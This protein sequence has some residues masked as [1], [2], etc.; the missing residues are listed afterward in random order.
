MIRKTPPIASADRVFQTIPAQAL[1][2]VLPVPVYVT[3]A[4]GRIIFFNPSAQAFAGREPA[5]GELWCV[6]W[7]MLSPDGTPLP[8]D[9]CPMAMALHERR[10]V[11]GMEAIAVRPDGSR[12]RF[13]PY[14][15][16]LFD[17]QG[18]LVGGINVLIELAEQEHAE[19]ALLQ[20]MSVRQP[21]T[22]EQLLQEN[23]MKESLHRSE[24]DFQL[25]VRSV[26]DYAIFMLDP[27][28]HIISWNSGA[29][30][31]KG[32]CEEEILNQHFSRFYTP[33][34]RAAGVPQFALAKALHDGRY[35]AEG[36]RVRK[37]GSRFWANVVIDPVWDKDVLVGFAKVTRDAT[38]RRDTDVALM[39]SER[40]ARGIIDTALDAFVQVDETGGITEWNPQAH[41][42]FGWS[43]ESTL[44][45]N[46]PQ[47]CFPPGDR[48]TV[49][50]FAAALRGEVRHPTHQVMVIDRVKRRFPVELSISTLALASGRLMNI[51]IRD[52]TDKIQMEN[53]LRQA[54]KMEA[55]GQLTGGIAHDFNNILQGISGSLEVMG[56]LGAH[57]QPERAE[58]HLRNALESVKRAAS[59]THRLLAFAR[60]QSLDPQPIDVVALLSSMTEL[61]RQTMGEQ[62]SLELGLSSDLWGVHCDTNQLENA[63]LNLAINARDAMP[64]GGRLRIDAENALGHDPEKIDTEAPEQP[65]VRITITDTGVGMSDETRQRAFDPFYTTK[66][67]GEGTGLGLSMVYGFARQSRGYCTID[68]EPD[69][70]TSVKLYLPRYIS[71]VQHAPVPERVNK[72]HFVQGEH[73]LVVEDEAVIRGVITEV[74]SNLGYDITQAV[75]GLEGVSIA[76]SDYPID[77]IV[78]DI[79]LPGVNGRSVA[80]AARERRPGLPVLLIT[81]YDASA[82]SNPLD[83]APGTALLSKPFTVDKLREQVSRLLEWRR[84]QTSSSQSDGE[85]VQS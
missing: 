37:D 46:L 31:I 15:T 14:P 43:R 45:K 34:D 58:K 27:D 75:D 9:Q 10:P 70:G 52:L 40:R 54:Q 76:V 42:L 12:V 3:D 84:E 41:A 59:L 17:E 28:G 85:V 62:I 56:M 38:T 68:S 82:A 35:E 55:M 11:R 69:E 60:R 23:T 61:L 47:L 80:E 6:T 78:T 49:E 13:M 22:P 26:T 67:A 57:G 50:W 36:W 83:L 2:E 19:A 77:L 39:E 72:P 71:K 18:E 51:F 7:R 25:L 16:P 29:E 4:Q 44:G 73:I 8:H 74:L 5:L 24:R 32:Y 21:A 33:E 63:I 48:S 81:G 1:L 30:R 66:A 64:N 53:Q 20:S 65:Y 79:G